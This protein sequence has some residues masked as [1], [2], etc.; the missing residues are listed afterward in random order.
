VEN[1]D[2]DGDRR[3]VPPEGR[4]SRVPTTFSIDSLLSHALQKKVSN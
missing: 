2:V 4:V 3:A 1:D